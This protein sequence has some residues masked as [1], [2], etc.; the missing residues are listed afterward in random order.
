MMAAID[1]VKARFNRRLQLLGYLVS[2]FKR[3]RSYQQSY[4]SQLRSH[5][6]PKTFDTVIPD[7]AQFERSVT[8]AVLLTRHAPASSAVG[9]ARQF[10]DETLRRCGEIAGDGIASRLTQSSALRAIAC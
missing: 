5:F 7:L 1:Y 2:R 6:G 4:L 10:F 8:D 3:R 9:I